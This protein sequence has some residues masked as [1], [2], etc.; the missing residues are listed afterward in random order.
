MPSEPFKLPSSTQLIK[1][2]CLLLKKTYPQAIGKIFLASLPYFLSFLFLCVDL[3]TYAYNRAWEVLSVLAVIFSL[4]FFSMIWLNAQIVNLFQK[5]TAS[6]P[7]ADGSFRTPIKALLSLGA[8]RFL[9]SLGLAFL[10]SL[11]PMALSLYF[12]FP[13][14]HR[15]T[16]LVASFFLGFLLSF[17]INSA[18]WDCSP[19]LLITQSKTAS[20]ALKLSRKLSQGLFW[21]LVWR[22]S[23]ISFLTYTLHNLSNQM[24]G[25]WFPF[26][27]LPMGLYFFLWIPFS[28]A[29][30]FTLSQHLLQ[31]E[32][33]PL[34]AAKL[35]EALLL[36]ALVALIILFS[37]LI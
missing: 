18:W 7:S 22:S 11:L 34:K 8:Q 14:A 28:Y 10:L 12:N 21:P 36:T 35:Q 6:L 31:R 9:L 26:S 29:Y 20:Q 4:A 15:P 24:A 5:V 30:F 27:L 3:T 32:S 16:Q 33:P 37:Y 1:E 13:T 2:S 25:Y 19:Y 23:L 17:P